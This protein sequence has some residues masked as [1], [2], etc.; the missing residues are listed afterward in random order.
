MRGPHDEAIFELVKFYVDA[1]RN[2]HPNP[3]VAD[4]L[5]EGNELRLKHSSGHHSGIDFGRN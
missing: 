1:V 2:E 5:R 3:A 4:K